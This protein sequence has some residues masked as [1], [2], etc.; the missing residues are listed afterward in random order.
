M[1][2]A[3]KMNKTT[4]AIA[5][6]RS[7]ERVAMLSVAGFL[8]IVAILAW[9]LQSGLDPVVNAGAQN[10]ADRQPVVHRRLIIK[11]KVVTAI[12][13]QP[14]ARETGSAA[15][16]TGGGQQTAS[17]APPQPVASAPA[18]APAPAPAPAPTTSA[19]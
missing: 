15:G 8:I 5:R 1:T 18:Q 11:R 7:A 2:M 19:S 10:T 4:K 3:A 9:R 14:V 12:V 16:A 13:D 17:S 6:R